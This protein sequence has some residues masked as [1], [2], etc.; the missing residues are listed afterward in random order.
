MNDEEDAA[1][2]GTPG[3]L[4]VTTIQQG[5]DKIFTTDKEFVRMVT[6]LA[7]WSNGRV[8]HNASTGHA[9]V[10]TELLLDAAKKH[11][12]HIRLVS[13]RLM[14]EFYSRLTTR[15]RDAM[16]AGARAEIL[17]TDASPKDL[18]ENPFYRAVLAHGNGTV[19]FLP[20]T[21]KEDGELLSA[22]HFIV[23]GTRRYRIEV[24][25][26]RRRA[27]ASFND[28]ATGKMLVGFFHYLKEEAGL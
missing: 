4:V 8:I 19:G 13:G 6:R 11:R 14:K 28:E 12:D 20:T 15:V 5:D 9:L 1:Q 18:V 16:E 3:E 24:D 26:E 23:I 17:I 2:H 21:S 10:L 25:H 27:M 22:P 7:R